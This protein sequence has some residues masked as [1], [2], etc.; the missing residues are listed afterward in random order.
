MPRQLVPNNHQS[1]DGRSETKLVAIACF[2]N[3]DGDGEFGVVPLKSVMGGVRNAEFPYLCA[4]PLLDQAISARLSDVGGGDH[5]H[6]T[7]QWRVKRRQDAL[8]LR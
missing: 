8:L 5:R 7:L 2:A 4:L 3:H 1:W 6:R